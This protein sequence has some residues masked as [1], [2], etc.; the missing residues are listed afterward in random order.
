MCLLL[1]I[2]QSLNRPKLVWAISSLSVFI[3]EICD[4]F[5]LRLCVKF[6]CLCVKSS[7]LCVKFLFFFA[8][9]WRVGGVRRARG[10]SVR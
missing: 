4:P 3:C 1:K 6:F 10:G 9:G 5:S 2:A 7:R 8:F